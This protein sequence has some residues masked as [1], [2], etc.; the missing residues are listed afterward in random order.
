MVLRWLAL[1]GRKPWKV[2]FSVE[3]PLAMSALMAALAPGIGKTGMPAA[4]AAAAI[5]EPGSAMPGVQASLTT[6]IFAPLFRS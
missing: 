2:K 5:C 3:R 6:A 4:M 1:A